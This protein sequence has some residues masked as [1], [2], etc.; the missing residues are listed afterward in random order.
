LGLGVKVAVHH[1][2]RRFYY[3]DGPVLDAHK[4]RV[5]NYVDWYVECNSVEN[6]KAVPKETY[7]HILSKVAEQPFRI[8]PL[9]YPVPWGGNWMKEVKNL[10]KE[11]PNS[12]QG[13]IV[14]SENSIRIVVNGKI[15][16]EMPFQNLLWAYPEKVLGERVKKM[17][18]GE[19]PFTYWYDDQ[20][21]GGDMAI[22]V[23]GSGRYLR[24]KFNERIRQD[25]SY[26]IVY[27]AEGLKR[28]LGSGRTLT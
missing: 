28:T 9:Y 15:L 25:E 2:I 6:L 22:Q 24:E 18:Q 8:K 4:K 7:S 23:H 1:L 3:V 19:F 21:G 14:A 16:I 10:P 11:M 12:G 5:L 13:C 27:T 17:F 26:Y 20:I